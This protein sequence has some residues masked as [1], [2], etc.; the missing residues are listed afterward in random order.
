MSEASPAPGS[1]LHLIKISFVS[2]QAAVL[3]LLHSYS[4]E[5][6]QTHEPLCCQKGHH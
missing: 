5:F 3:L 2:V 6:G 4:F 1:Q